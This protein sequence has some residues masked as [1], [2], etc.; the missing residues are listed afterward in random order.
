MVEKNTSRLDEKSTTESGALPKVEIY[1][2][3]IFSKTGS[4][5]NPQQRFPKPGGH[6]HTHWWYNNHHFHNQMMVINDANCN[7][8]ACPLPCSIIRA[9]PCGAE[10]WQMLSSCVSRNNSMLSSKI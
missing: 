9:E 1:Y 3:Y 5:S 2:N 8:Q 4:P 6:L 7:W 10:Q